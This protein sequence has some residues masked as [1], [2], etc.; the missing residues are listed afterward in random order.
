MAFVLQALTREDAEEGVTF[1]QEM[2]ELSQTQQSQPDHPARLV[3][4]AHY[5]SKDE[6]KSDNASSSVVP[7]H[8]EDRFAAG[9]QSETAEEGA[10]GARSTRKS[11]AGG[12][13]DNILV[14]SIVAGPAQFGL[15]LVGDT[16]VQGE[17]VV[18]SP[19]RACETLS[20][21]DEVKGKIVIVERGDCLFIDKARVLQRLGAIGGIVVDNTDSPAEGSQSEEELPMFAMS[22]DNASDDVTIPFVFLYRSPAQELLHAISVAASGQLTAMLSD[23]SSKGSKRS[24]DSDSLVVSLEDIESS[25]ESTT[26]VVRALLRARTK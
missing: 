11:G 26:P 19:Y 16:V 18:A 15:Q 25:R 7:P 20:N 17:V 23:A 14:K 3:T 13:G 5:A 24:K 6:I 1:M 21:D 8:E 9:K 4:F 22:G 12:S 2:I 10:E